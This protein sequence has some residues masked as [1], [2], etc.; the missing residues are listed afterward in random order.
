[1]LTVIDTPHKIKGSAAM[2]STFL[3]H[4]TLDV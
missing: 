3:Y 4:V 1:M 2:L